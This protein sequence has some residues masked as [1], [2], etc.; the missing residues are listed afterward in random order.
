MAGQIKLARQRCVCATLRR[1]SRSVTQFYDAVLR[2]SGLRATQFNILQEIRHGGERSLSGLTA[3][4]C[5]DQTTLTRSLALLERGGLIKSIPQE[6][7]RLKTVRL[8]VKGSRALDRA[9]C[10]WLKAQSRAVASIGV[11]KWA[12]LSAQIA[13]LAETVGV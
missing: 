5:I 13:R 2:P 10:L 8:T 7:R 4:M 12:T 9:E 6:D 3:S 11:R 1:A